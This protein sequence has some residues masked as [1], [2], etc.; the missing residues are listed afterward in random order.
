MRTDHLRLEALR[1]DATGLESQ[2]IVVFLVKA[3]TKNSRNHCVVLI[4]NLRKTKISIRL[5][6]TVLSFFHYFYALLQ[7]NVNQGQPS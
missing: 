3:K 6:T 4:P 5:K 2:T 1:K 7:K